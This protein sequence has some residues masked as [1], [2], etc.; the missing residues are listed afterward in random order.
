M[1]KCKLHP[2]YFGTKP[3]REN[4]P[5]CEAMWEL[6]PNRKRNVK[7]CLCLQCKGRINNPQKELFNYCFK[8]KDMCAYK[9]CIDCLEFDCQVTECEIINKKID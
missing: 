9:K 3:P 8:T 5:D 2:M 4:C 7:R 1:K 6:S